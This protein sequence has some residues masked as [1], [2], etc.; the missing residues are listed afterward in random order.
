METLTHIKQTQI[1]MLRDRGYNVEAEINILE[2]TSAEFETHFLELARTN[3]IK[4]CP[5]SIRP[6][7]NRLYRHPDG[8]S[9]FVYYAGQ[10]KSKPKSAKP[11]AKLHSAGSTKV[12]ITRNYTSILTKFKPEASILI[13]NA[14]LASVANREVYQYMARHQIQFQIF[15]ELDLTY[16]PVMHVDTPVH[17]R[18][19]DAEKILQLEAMRVK[20]TDL[21]LIRSDDPIAKYYGWKA[22]DLIRIHRRDRPGMTLGS[23]SINYRVVVAPFVA[24]NFSLEPESKVTPA[25]STDDSGHNFSTMETSMRNTSIPAVQPDRKIDYLHYN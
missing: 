11:G 18:L 5:G 22:G 19:S 23:V 6:I 3:K 14:P 12:Q 13:L 10:D 9:I 8:T 7:L 16:N 20:I 2:M 25:Q 1:E 24:H 15:F 21:P 17:V 4:L